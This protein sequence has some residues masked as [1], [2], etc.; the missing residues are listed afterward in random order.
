MDDTNS[1][2]LSEFLQNQLPSGA[3]EGLALW[4]SNSEV[5]R[6]SPARGPGEGLSL[7]KASGEVA[8]VSPAHGLPAPPDDPLSLWKGAKGAAPSAEELQL[9]KDST[10]GSWKNG[11]SHCTSEADLWKGADTSS[12][13]ALVDWSDGRERQSGVWKEQDTATGGEWNKKGDE[14]GSVWKSNAA[15]A[16]TSN[17]TT[18]EDSWKKSVSLSE[19][20]QNGDS[21]TN[22]M[23]QKTQKNIEEVWEGGSGEKEAKK[24]WL[25][26]WKEEAG[27]PGLRAARLTSTPET[28]AVAH[29]P[30]ALFSPPLRRN[31]V[32]SFA[33]SHQE[34]LLSLDLHDLFEEFIPE[35]GKPRRP[36]PSSI[37][38]IINEAL[39]TGNEPPPSHASLPPSLI[40]D[41]LDEVTNLDFLSQD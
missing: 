30:S 29:G 11:D 14:E 15:A 34:E 7:W 6:S 24:D 37:E 21:A 18:K 32:S 25:R 13:A 4:K 27:M 5:T 16:P 40:P 35:Q 36:K 33:P 2:F 12:E 22:S 10:G 17:Q 8:H 38:S 39:F 20:V 9:W 28:H 19:A 3:A 1:E 31:S 26:Q 41:T 23:W